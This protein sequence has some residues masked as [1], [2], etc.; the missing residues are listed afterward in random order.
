MVDDAE[1]DR[2]QAQA[3][4]IA[5]AGKTLEDV[6]NGIRHSNEPADREAARR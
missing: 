4:R 2:L 1:S 6:L 5:E 3:E